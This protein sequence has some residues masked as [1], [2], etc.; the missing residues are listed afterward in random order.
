[1]TMATSSQEVSVPS[2]MATFA[3]YHIPPG[4]ICKQRQKDS[5]IQGEFQSKI[6]GSYAGSSKSDLC[7]SRSV[8]LGSSGILESTSLRTASAGAASWHMAACAHMRSAFDHDDDMAPSSR[9]LLDLSR[10]HHNET[11]STSEVD[12]RQLRPLNILAMVPD[13]GTN[14]W[15]RCAHPHRE[16]K[17]NGARSLTCIG[18]SNSEMPP[19]FDEP[20]LAPPPRSSSGEPLRMRRPT[21]ASFAP[22]HDFD[23]ACA[24][25]GRETCRQ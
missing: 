19:G 6:L 25:V 24:Y 23:R 8:S 5:S 16:L 22:Q 15:Q 11:E 13:E 18:T 21:A 12:E 1:M 2:V 10:R 3:P 20:N 7:I 4:N 17:R 9:F 14:P